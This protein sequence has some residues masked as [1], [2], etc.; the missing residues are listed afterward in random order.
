LSETTKV[1][2]KVA[3]NYYFTLVVIASN[4]FYFSRSQFK[5]GPAFLRDSAGW[6]QDVPLSNYTVDGSQCQAFLLIVPNT[7]TN[8]ALLDIRFGGE[9]FYPETYHT[10]TGSP[11]VIASVAQ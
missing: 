2:P 6:R 1:R 8:S 4:I 3:G 11:F 5:R 7:P 9:P 10:Q